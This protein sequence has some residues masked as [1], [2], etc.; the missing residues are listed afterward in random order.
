MSKRKSDESH[1]FQQQQQKRRRRE[2]QKSGSVKLKQHD[3]AIHHPLLHHC[4]QQV[5]PL[6]H[7]LTDSLSRHS[8]VQGKNFEIFCQKSVSFCTHLERVLVGTAIEDDRV[9]AVHRRASL[10]RFTQAQRQS[11][12]SNDSTRECSWNEVHQ[13]PSP[14]VFSGTANTCLDSGVR[15]L[16]S[17]R[18]V[19]TTLEEAEPCLM[20][21][22]PTIHD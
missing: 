1:E 18:P 21:W 11:Q 10:L 3:T 12:R 17:F 7:Y 16:A 22:S 20:P 6:K 13:L 2:N 15:R 4:Y 19:Q 9:R 5:L 8:Q 14:P